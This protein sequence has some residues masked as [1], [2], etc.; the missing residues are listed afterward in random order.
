MNEHRVLVVDDEPTICWA[1][2]RM[3]T[4]DGHQVITTSS[5]EEGLQLA[6]S[7]L[8]SMVLL[9]IRLPHEDG[10]SAL[11]K[12][13][14]ATK[15]APVIV[16][17]AFGDLETAVAALKQG[18]VDYLTKP[19]RLDD[20]QRIC[21]QTLRK[22]D[23][24]A[25]TTSTQ[26]H[27]KRNTLV[28]QSPG[29]Q[30]VFRQ[31]ALVADSDL[32]VLIT[33]ETGTGKELVAA[34]IHRHSRRESL[35]YLRI[36]PVALNPDLIESELF[37]HA[38]GAFTGA[39][40][41]RIGLFEQAQ[42]GTVLLDEIGDLPLGIQVKLLR[43]LEQG[44]FCRVGDVSIRQ[45]DFRLIAATNCELYEAVSDGRFREDLFHRLSGMQIHLPALRSRT[46]DLM[47][48]C[49]HFLMLAEYPSPMSAIDD[50]LIRELQTRPWHGNV[51]EL[52]SAIEHATV[53]ARGRPLSIADFPQAKPKRGDESLSSSG[54]SLDE[55]IRS[56][57]RRAI[58]KLSPDSPPL[59]A[60]F[61]TTFEPALLAV[62]LEYTEGNRAK[63]A[64]LLGIHR[65][66]L[67]DR[68]R[69]HGIDDSSLGST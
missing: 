59:H 31:I 18:A 6:A 14:Q 41:D 37:G 42:G 9:D 24:A 43:V 15:Q 19:F 45:A 1:L 35:P 68:L 63:A 28:G 67:R 49:Q 48:L 36:S 44:E 11:P 58:T 60:Q 51:R 27:A 64:E 21:R 38:K 20:V 17:T 22:L 3:L 52:K 65:S 26:S 32:S 29:M 62:A 8:P 40:D 69:A 66:T 16:M 10:I 5:A 34:A 50:E 54:S 33:G 12:F 23:N 2:K 53:I 30:Q 25:S 47:L 55:P 46:E 56:W 7:E 57:A 61:L 13:I 39:T 4:E